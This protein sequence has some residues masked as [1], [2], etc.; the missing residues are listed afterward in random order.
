M[1]IIL[2]L[3][4][5]A[6]SSSRF[7]NLRRNGFYNHHR[8]G[9]NFRRSSQ[10]STNGA[11]QKIDNESERPVFTDNGILYD[12]AGPEVINKLLMYERLMD[13]RAGNNFRRSSQ[14]SPNGVRQKMDNESER[15]IFTDNEIF[16]DAAG[17]EVINELLMNDMV[18][19][20]MSYI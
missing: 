19:I 16:H 17:P 12:A 13:D 10:S 15:P 3:L 6:S 4:S 18:F 14:S 8:A 5:V 2:I 20:Y 7:A 9:N 11:R 1:K